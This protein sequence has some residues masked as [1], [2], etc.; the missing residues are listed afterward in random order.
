MKK[1]WLILL[2]ISTAVFSQTKYSSLNDACTKNALGSGFNNS[3]KT[4]YIPA[5][6]VGNYAFLNNSNRSFRRLARGYYYYPSTNSAFQTNLRGMITDMQSCAM[7]AGSLSVV[8]QFSTGLT[9]DSGYQ[10]DNGG[11]YWYYQPNNEFYSQFSV[12]PT[13]NNFVQVALDTR[14]FGNGQGVVKYKVENSINWLTKQQLEAIDFSNMKGRDVS[15]MACMFDGNNITET[16]QSIVHFKGDNTS[17]VAS[18]YKRNSTNR[19]PQLPYVFPEFGTLTDKY[20]ILGFGQLDGSYNYQNQNYL[21]RGFNV[22][23]WK[24]NNSIPL[25]NRIGASYDE[26]AYDNGAPRLNGPGATQWVANTPIQNL[27]GWF[28][29][30]VIQ[31]AANHKFFFVDFEA[32]SYYILDNQVAADKMASLFRAFKQANPNVLLMSYVGTRGFK[33]ST[34]Q[35]ITQPEMLAENNKYNQSLAQVAKEFETKTVNYINVSTGQYD[36]TSGYLSEYI[37]VINA[38]DYQHFI[39]HSWFYSTIQEFELAKLYH[40]SKKVLALN[41]SYVETVPGSDFNSVRRYHKKTND[42]AY[43]FVDYKVAVPFSHMYNVT[44]WANF[45]GDGTWNWH[46][47]YNAVEGFDYHGL[48]GKD[49]I[50]GQKKPGLYST[51]VGMMEVSTCIGYD[52][53]AMALYELKQNDTILVGNQPIQRVDFSTDNGNSYYTGEQLK[54]ASADFYHIPVVRVKKHPSK[55]EWLLLAVNRYNEMWQNQTIKVKIPG[56]GQT[57][58]VILYGQYTSIRRI[59]LE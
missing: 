57:V 15:I 1:I 51:N 58:D 42:S 19:L 55:N 9:G 13:V 56:T 30:Y 48:A 12:T 33:S 7:G 43:Y 59:K 27:Y 39:S 49:P 24:L 45:I 31:P 32:W 36:G 46:D 5:V 11:S 40:P 47:P 6:S 41:W 8:N 25:I 50:S 2:L 52:Q 26:W 54:P 29:S 18:F 44:A 23:D 34:L 21:T 3:D 28:N 14:G 17:K 37:D 38:G 20:N 16:K 35:Q 4:I 10:V 22:I 53:V